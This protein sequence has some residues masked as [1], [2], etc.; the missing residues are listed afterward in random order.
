[1]IYQ[2]LTLPGLGFFLKLGPAGN[3]SRMGYARNLKFGI[4][5]TTNKRCKKS[6]SINNGYHVTSIISVKILKIPFYSSERKEIF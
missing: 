1:M 3:I 5:V 4:V 6:C 2:S